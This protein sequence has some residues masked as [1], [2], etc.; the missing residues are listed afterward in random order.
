MT[1]FA[2]ICEEPVVLLGA[3]VKQAQAAVGG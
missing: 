2:E 3:C 1:L